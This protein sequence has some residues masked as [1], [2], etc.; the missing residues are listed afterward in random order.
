M[1]WRLSRHWAEPSPTP[2]I[3][4]GVNQPGQCCTKILGSSSAVPSEQSQGCPPMHLCLPGVGAGAVTFPQRRQRSFLGSFWELWEWKGPWSQCKMRERKDRGRRW[5]WTLS[6]RFLGPR[7]GSEF[8]A[9][10]KADRWSKAVPPQPTR[11]TGCLSCTCARPTFPATPSDRCPRPPPPPQRP[12]VPSSAPPRPAPG[13]GLRW[14]PVE[15][16][17]PRSRRSG[18]WPR[19]QS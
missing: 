19:S 8:R 4:P 15:P 18:G 7:W 5:E 1:R 6:L 12:L 11:F 14:E 16:R 13:S 3:T 17:V 9:E 2:R 10:L